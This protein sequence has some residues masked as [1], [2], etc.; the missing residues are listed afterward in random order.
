[1]YNDSELDKIF[2]SYNKIL[3]KLKLLN[4]KNKT[5]NE[6]THK[7]LRKAITIMEKKHKSCRWKFQRPKK[8]KNYILIE[9][10]YWLV[11]VYFNND[12]KLID[13]DIDFFEE[14]IKLYEELL[15]LDHKTL[16]KNDISVNQLSDYF[17]KK[18]STIQ[19]A[20]LKMIK[21]NP[22]YRYKTNT[23]YVITREGIEWLCKN[24]FKDKYLKLL[25]DYKMKLTEK[26]MQEGYVYDNFLNKF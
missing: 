18:E 10:F 26:Y 5:G 9:G 12:K 23:E 24:C 17:D 22:N 7:D 20:I 13:A 4:I 19:K 1:M 6:I 3:Y 11:Y 25:E 14:R 8:N 16:F 21:V 15:K 2:L